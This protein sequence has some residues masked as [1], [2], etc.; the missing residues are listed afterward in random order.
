MTNLKK[1][2]ILFLIT[3]C[4]C[5]TIIWLKGIP[6][7][8]IYYENI[9]E[10]IY[11][12]P[13]F[14]KKKYECINQIN[15]KCE[16]AGN[17]KKILL[18]GDSK[19]MSLQKKLVNYSIKNKHSFFSIINNSCT[20]IYNK[21]VSYMGKERKRCNQVNLDTEKYLEKNVNNI[22]IYNARYKCNPDEEILFENKKIV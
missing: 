9:Y 13:Y 4:V 1:I 18:I 21:K 2:L 19:A 22:I 8:N 5:L 6:E 15:L 14:M 20:F 16:I 7:R 12:K 10:G 17:R 3:I 11:I